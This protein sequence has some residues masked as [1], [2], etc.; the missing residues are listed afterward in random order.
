M[1]EGGLPWLRLLAML[2]IFAVLFAVPVITFTMDERRK[3]KDAA[4]DNE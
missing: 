4:I 2:G 3:R 1:N